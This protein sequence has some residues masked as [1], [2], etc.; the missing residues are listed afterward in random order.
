MGQSILKEKSYSFALNV[1][2]ALYQLQS[3]KKEFILTKQLIR[4]GTA[5]GALIEEAGQGES[6]KDFIHKLSIANK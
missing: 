1:V 3:D 4:S 2:K 6:I 5:I